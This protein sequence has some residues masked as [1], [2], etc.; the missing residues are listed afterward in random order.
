MLLLPHRSV[1]L[2]IIDWVKSVFQMVSNYAVLQVESFC[3]CPISASTPWLFR[4]LVLERTNTRLAFLSISSFP[5][6]LSR[7]RLQSSGPPSSFK[8][9][10][11][12]PPSSYL[13]NAYFADNLELLLL[14]PSPYVAAIVSVL[15]QTV[16]VNIYKKYK[17]SAWL[18]I[19]ISGLSIC[20]LLPVRGRQGVQYPSE[21]LRILL[22]LLLL[23]TP[24]FLVQCSRITLH[25]YRQRSISCK[26]LETILLWLVVFYCFSSSLCSWTIHAQYNRI[27]LVHLAHIFAF[28]CL[29]LH[30]IYVLPLLDVVAWRCPEGADLRLTR[31]RFSGH[32]HH[33]QHHS[34]LLAWSLNVWLVG[35][36]N[37]LMMNLV[38]QEPRT[39]PLLCI[40]H[41]VRL[42]VVDLSV[43]KRADNL[44]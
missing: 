14:L 21:L 13:S 24:L 20:S 30:V 41:T 29:S 22:V 10:H 37:W 19:F 28:P 16:A 17:A 34:L 3:S 44:S 39:R 26:C 27:L 11:C 5:Y 4:R 31:L 35:G 23:P 38:C 8:E 36:L 1:E 42:L 33:H 2:A 12:H 7:G 43:H 9:N 6:T 18:I 32:P 15:N 25:G 40:P